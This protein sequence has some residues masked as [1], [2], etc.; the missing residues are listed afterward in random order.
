MQ[1]D[2]SKA[3]KGLSIATIVISALSIVFSGIIIAIIGFMMSIA[4]SSVVDYSSSYPY[5]DD[6]YYDYSYIDPDE[7]IGAYITGIITNALLGWAILCSIFTLVTGIIGLRFGARKDKLGLVFGWSIAGAVV[8]FLGTGMIVAVLMIITA[9]FANKDKQLYAAGYVPV[10]PGS[11]VYVQMP[12]PGAPVVAQPVVAPVA[13]PVATPVT[14]VAAQP[15]DPVAIPAAPAATPATS[16][17][18]SPV[19]SPVVA[20]EAPADQPTQIGETPKQC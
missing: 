17:V 11:S 5:Y 4:D 6:Y 19:A 2:H 1:Q 10:S 7:Y 18:A 3:I 9:V 16:P 20:P 13:A 15:V 12:A 8:G 14:P